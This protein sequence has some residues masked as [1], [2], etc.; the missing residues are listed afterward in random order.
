MS[1]YASLYQT[2]LTALYNGL[3][4]LTLGA[5]GL[6]I[7]WLVIEWI[8]CNSKI[9]RVLEWIFLAWCA[10]IYVGLVFFPGE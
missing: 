10:A 6:M 1:T 9:R 4:T 7:T 5:W 3:I 2:Y 8:H